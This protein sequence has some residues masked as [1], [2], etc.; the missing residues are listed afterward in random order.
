LWIYAGSQQPKALA[1]FHK[2]RDPVNRGQIFKPFD[3]M[4]NFNNFFHIRILKF[5]IQPCPV[6]GDEAFG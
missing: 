4:V 3:Q 2:K 5:Q 1:F 6:F